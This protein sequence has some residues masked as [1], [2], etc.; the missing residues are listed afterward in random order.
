MK[1]KL[2]YFSIAAVFFFAYSYIFL[3]YFYFQHNEKTLAPTIENILP[4]SA[5]KVT[6]IIDGDTFEIE[7][8]IKVR[9]IGV[10]TP[11]MKNKN[12]T[13][14][15]FASEAKKKTEELLTGKEVVL[16]KDVSETDK[17]GRLLRYVYVGDKMIN[18]LLVLEGYARIS[19][20][21][22]DVKYK[23]LFLESE[24]SARNAKAGL[25]SSCK[26]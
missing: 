23:D 26:I 8:G 24:R 19:T 2:H 15:C 10:D 7:G 17:Y 18:N 12:K 14:D 20:F 16:E 5:E 11:E 22:P 6:R 13:I 1:P 3:A 25:W 9:L 21:P 4:R